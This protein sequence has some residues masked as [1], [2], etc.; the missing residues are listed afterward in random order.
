M[1]A[2][3][4]NDV[5]AAMGPIMTADHRYCVV[6]VD[7]EDTDLTL[8]S[9]DDAVQ[10]SYNPDRQRFETV[11]D[12][13]LMCIGSRAAPASNGHGLRAFAGD[14]YFDYG[15]SQE[16][17]RLM[18]CLQSV[19]WMSFSP[20]LWRRDTADSA[21][22]DRWVNA[23]GLCMAYDGSDYVDAMV[24]TPCERVA[25]G[26]GQGRYTSRFVHVPNPRGCAEGED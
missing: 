18:P 2:R 6:F 14:A 17:L 10:F 4:P 26:A 15:E 25:G 9:C 23:H 13:S 21:S 12:S 1:A 7:S 5:D 22:C 20:Q 3:S 19:G 24:E 11:I 16:T 8:G